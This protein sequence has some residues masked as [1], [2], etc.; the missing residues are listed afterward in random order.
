MTYITQKINLS[1]KNVFVEVLTK[2]TYTTIQRL[3]KC[4]FGMVSIRDGVHSRSCH[5][6]SCHSGS[7]QSR[8][9]QSGSCHSRWCPFGKVSIRDRANQMMSIR[10]RAFGQL[11]GY[12]YTQ[13]KNDFYNAIFS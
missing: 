6:G 9:Y 10:D 7:Y 1:L 5:S 4:S 11:S 13:R 3:Y 8:S 12:R 2:Y